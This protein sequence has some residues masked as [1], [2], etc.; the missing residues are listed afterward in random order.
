M[1]PRQTRRRLLSV[2]ASLVGGLAG[3]SGEDPDDGKPS[4]DTSTGRSTT[5]RTTASTTTRQSSTTPANREP[6]C[7]RFDLR[8][9]DPAGEPVAGALVETTSELR[10]RTDAAGEAALDDPGLMGQAVFV[11]ITHEDYHVP[12]DRFGVAGHTVQVRP[13]G[14]ATVAVEPDR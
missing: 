13:G 8:V 3:C 14:T 10:Y 7:P 5:D 6:W 11:E 4:T 12:E 1:L 2:A 9:V